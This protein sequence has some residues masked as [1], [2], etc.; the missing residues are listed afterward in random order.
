MELTDYEV[1]LIEKIRDY[2]RNIAFHGGTQLI[3]E[4]WAV[5]GQY[6]AK[7]DNLYESIIQ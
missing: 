1:E 7:L 6:M 3:I 2:E 5:D 4:A